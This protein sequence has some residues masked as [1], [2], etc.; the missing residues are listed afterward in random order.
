MR[1]A[2]VLS[3]DSEES[4]PELRDVLAAAGLRVMDDLTPDGELIVLLGPATDT[5]A[6]PEDDV[7][8]ALRAHGHVGQWETSRQG[9]RKR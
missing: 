6:Q 3:P 8:A 7:L 5:M 9:S 1:R 2:V 4:I